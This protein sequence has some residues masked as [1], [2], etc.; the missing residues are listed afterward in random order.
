LTALICDG[1]RKEIT[2]QETIIGVYPDRF[3][4]DNF[5][6]NFAFAVYLRIKFSVSEQHLVE[7][8]IIQTGGVPLIQPAK[9]PVNPQKDETTTIVMGPIGITIQ[10]PGQVKFG[11]RLDQAQWDDVYEI[12]FRK[13]DARAP[14]SVPVL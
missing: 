9:F 2:G 13:I 10:S 7:F 11:L 14:A 8:R 5:P 6:I 12:D 3:N 4:S 1:V